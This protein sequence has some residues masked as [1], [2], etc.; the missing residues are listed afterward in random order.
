MNR[1]MPI[2]T[3]MFNGCLFLMGVGVLVLFRCVLKLV[4]EMNF[5]WRIS[6]FHPNSHEVATII[7]HMSNMCPSTTS[8]WE[9]IK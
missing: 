5:F 8:F 4:N 2:D 7:T 9:G 6:E 1:Y 3:S